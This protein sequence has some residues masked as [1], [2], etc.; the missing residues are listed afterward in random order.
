MTALSRR[1]VLGGASLAVVAAGAA[2]I[3]VSGDAST[4]PPDHSDAALLALCAEFWRLDEEV[5][6]SNESFNGI[7][8]VKESNRLFDS[9]NGGLWR[10]HSAQIDRIVS[11]K[12][13]TVDGIRAKAAVAHQVLHQNSEF[14]NPWEGGNEEERLALSLINDILGGH[15]H[16]RL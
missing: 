15:D 1:G 2:L 8:D 3:S 6:A 7:T 13:H 11:T 16:A 9:Y 10:E 4:V 12:A 5:D 14:S